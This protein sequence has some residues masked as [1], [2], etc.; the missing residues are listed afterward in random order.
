MTQFKSEDG[1]VLRFA[2]DPAGRNRKQAGYVELQLL[3]GR[4]VLTIFDPSMGSL[5]TNMLISEEDGVALAASIQDN[6]LTARRNRDN[7]H[8]PDLFLD[9]YAAFSEVDNAWQTWVEGA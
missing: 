9:S 4:L 7:G 5:P 2:G 1:T 8:V 6:V 3:E